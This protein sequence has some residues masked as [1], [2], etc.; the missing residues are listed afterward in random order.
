MLHKF[1]LVI[2]DFLR[3]EDYIK[4]IEREA[5]KV[6]IRVF[7]VENEFSSKSVNKISVDYE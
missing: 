7:K 6:Y 3:N 4:K 1:D 5:R 2:L